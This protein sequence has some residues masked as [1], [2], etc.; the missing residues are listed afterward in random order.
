MPA[1][2]IMPLRARLFGSTLMISAVFMDQCTTKSWGS[3]T[4]GLHRGPPQIL[5]VTIEVSFH[6]FIIMLSIHSR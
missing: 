1:R 6:D 3:Q 5:C 4:L 2:A